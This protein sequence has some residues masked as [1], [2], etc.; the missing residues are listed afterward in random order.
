MSY[1]IGTFPAIAMAALF[2]RK[3]RQRGGSDAS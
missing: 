1:R 3:L 2:F